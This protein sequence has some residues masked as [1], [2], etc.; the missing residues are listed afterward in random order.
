MGRGAASSAL[1]RLQDLR[2]SATSRMA[3]SR[4]ILLG[5]K[6]HGSWRFWRVLVSRRCSRS[7]FWEAFARV[8]KHSLLG[9][10]IFPPTSRCRI[11]G[12]GPVFSRWKAPQSVAV[13][14]GRSLGDPAEARS[15]HADRVIL[16]TSRYHSRRVRV[17][18]NSLVGDYP[19][20]IVRYT[21]RD[22]YDPEHWWWAATSAPPHLQYYDWRPETVLHARQRR[23]PNA[24]RPQA[25]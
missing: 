6:G 25:L 1:W 22:P 7:Q 3:V 17:L 8:S 4:P 11:R 9:F 16:I 23:R 14:V 15:A 13:A 21:P 18:W 20:A 12:A 2:R 19:Q 10:E 5:T 24:P